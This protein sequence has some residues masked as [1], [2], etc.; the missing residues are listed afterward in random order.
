MLLIRGG[1]LGDRACPIQLIS[2]AVNRHSNADAQAGAGGYVQCPT[3]TTRA[4][5]IEEP[6]QLIK[7]RATGR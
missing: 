1:L 2:V 5:A 4:L 6:H 3:A 7:V